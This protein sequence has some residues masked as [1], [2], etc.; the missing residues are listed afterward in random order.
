[1]RKLAILLMIL[2]LA[3]VCL[4]EAGNSRP[5]P[6]GTEAPQ[7]GRFSPAELKSFAALNP[8]DTHSHVY[9]TDPAFVAMLK[10][11]N[12]HLLDICLTNDRGSLDK[13]LPREIR[14]AK[15]FIRSSNGH[16]ALCTSFNPYPFQ[17]EGFAGAAIREINRDFAE[18][19]VA[20]KIWKNV[21]MEIKDSQGRYVMP[22]NPVFEPIYRDIAAHSKTLIA[23]LAE[24]D[25]CW[26]PL[27]PAS[28]DYWYYTHHPEWYMYGKPGAPTKEEILR[29]R[30]H[31]LEKNPNLRVIG[32]H[33]GSM[34]SDFNALA[35]HLDRY[36]NFAVDMAARMPYIMMQ[37]RE[38]MIAFL[39]KYQD[40]LIYA[41][42]LDYGPG[43]SSLEIIERW[44]DAYARDWRFLAT[45]DWV[46]YLGKKYQGLYLP[47]PVLEKLYH[48]NA[49][50]WFPGIL[51]Q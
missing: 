36:P 5:L 24:P 41:T 45:D 51:G 49:V 44:E 9:V 26:K 18:G 27:D 23:H 39:T 13:D 12:V 1:M 31:L 46:E 35:Q 20:V 33:L 19:A 21:G 37:P 8:I 50:R 7:R 32:A 40:R 47:Q 16:A 6:P 10:R 17:R 43:A 22:D 42:D 28:P 2:L 3:G 48:S 4:E 30:D 38:G 15:E 25:S 29:A 11:L 34:E 14:Y